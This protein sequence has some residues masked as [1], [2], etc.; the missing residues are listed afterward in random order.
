MSYWKEVG[1]RLGELQTEHTQQVNKLTAELQRL[2]GEQSRQVKEVSELKDRF[3]RKTGEQV[4]SLKDKHEREIQELARNGEM[5]RQKH[6]KD[7]SSLRG[8]HQNDQERLRREHKLELD[9]EREKLRQIQNKLVSEEAE[10]RQEVERSLRQEFTE[11]EESLKQQ[12]SDLSSELRATKDKLAL[13]EQRVREMELYCQE[14]KEDSNSLKD[15]LQ[16][17]VEEREQLRSTIRT[18]ES[19]VEIAREQYRLQAV[20][21]QGLSGERVLSVCVC[22]SPC[23]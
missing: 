20:E 10:K 5:E 7:L 6:Q 8:Q 4:K 12:V 3:A 21:M 23:V 16:A 15:K 18:L 17:A 9:G 11:R 1:E 13:A 19:E 2:K 22:V 14:D